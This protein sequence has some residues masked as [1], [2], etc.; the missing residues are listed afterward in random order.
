[1]TLTLPP[2]TTFNSSSLQLAAGLGTR[3]NLQTIQ[4]LAI[5]KFH[6]NSLQFAGVPEANRISKL[7][8]ERARN[9]N[10][11]ANFMILGQKA[12]AL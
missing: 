4:K 6:E 5:C 11:A 7:E 12:I 9:F 1:M 2:R 10:L 8:T 3:C